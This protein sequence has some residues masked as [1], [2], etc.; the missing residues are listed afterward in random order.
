MNWVVTSTKF[1]YTFS[2]LNTDEGFY[3][4]Y[5]LLKSIQLPYIHRST[6]QHFISCEKQYTQMKYCTN[7]CEN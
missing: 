4:Q 6:V 2:P 1:L 7:Q 3:L 5:L